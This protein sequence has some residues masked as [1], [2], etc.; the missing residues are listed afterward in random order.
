MNSSGFNYFF[1]IVGK[2]DNPLFELGKYRV[3][4]R[5]NSKSNSRN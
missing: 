2:S 3:N 5:L 4:Q 1:V